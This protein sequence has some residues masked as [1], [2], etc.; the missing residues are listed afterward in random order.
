MFIFNRHVPI[1]PLLFIGVGLVLLIGLGVGVYVVNTQQTD[2]RSKASTAGSATLQNFVSGVGSSITLNTQPFGVSDRNTSNIEATASNCCGGN[3]MEV[4][5]NNASDVENRFEIVFPEKIVEVLGLGT[6]ETAESPNTPYLPNKLADNDFGPGHLQYGMNQDDYN[7]DKGRMKTPVVVFPTKKL[8][9]AYLYNDAMQLRFERDSKTTLV[10]KKKTALKDTANKAKVLVVRGA[11]IEEVYNNYY[12]AL[13]EEGYFFKNPNYA[14]FGPY[15]ETYMDMSCTTNRAGYERLLNSFKSNKIIPSLIVIGSGYWEGA[16]IGCTNKE[17]ARDPIGPLT[18]T[19]GA[20]KTRWN[21]ANGLRQFIDKVHTELKIPILIGMRY[22]VWWA[23]KPAKHREEVEKKILSYSDRYPGV[24]AENIWLNKGQYF[25]GAAP[26]VFGGPFLNLRNDDAIKA[27]HQAVLDSYG[28]V[29]GYKEDNMGVANQSLPHV[30]EYIKGINRDSSYTNLHGKIPE[31]SPRQNLSPDLIPNSY[32]VVNEMTNNKA[33]IIGR[34][35]YLNVGTDAQNT[36]GYFS[37][38]TKWM[39]EYQI[40]YWL[41]MM[42][43]QIASGYPTPVMEYMAYPCVPLEIGDEWTQKDVEESSFTYAESLGGASPEK[44]AFRIHQLQT[45][46]PVA[47][48]SCDYNTRFTKNTQ[49]DG[50]KKVMNFYGAL[51]NRLHDYAY[52]QAQVWYDTGVP[53]LMKP[54]LLDNDYTNLAESKKMLAPCGFFDPEAVNYGTDKATIKDEASAKNC[55]TDG[56][57][58]YQYMFGNALM[59]RPIMSAVDTVAVYLPPGKWRSFIVAN[60]VVD[61]GKTIKYTPKDAGDYPVFLKEGEILLIG[62]VN[63]TKD[64][65]AYAFL[66][67]AG[68][69]E[70]SVYKHVNA[71]TGAKTEL[72]V[73]KQGT[74]LY[75]KDLGSKRQLAMTP[76]VYGKGFYVAKLSALATAPIADTSRVAPTPTPTPRATATPRPTLLPV[77]TTTPRP[78]ARPSTAPTLTPSNDVVALTKQYYLQLNASIPSVNDVKFRTNSALVAQNN[79]TAAIK[80]VTALPT[81]QKRKGPS[82]EKYTDVQYVTMLSRA[83]LSKN[84][85]KVQLKQ[86]T[87]YLKNKKYTRDTIIDFF[88]NSSTAQSVCKAKTLYRNTSF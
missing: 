87:D 34:N 56:V 24:N 58:A 14:V 4:T 73:I 64:L 2:S 52:D 46:L 33:I 57:P 67:T 51:R 32:K 5:Y 68:K 7:G 45:F 53:T 49:N 39:R 77:R 75:L 12:K 78:T 36:G 37:Y 84:P 25:S 8:L 60:P 63:N 71:A 31:V 29:D 16:T 54:L 38:N 41:Q 48:Y 21:G 11:T 44:Q 81:F 88:A 74:T 13:K 9:I 1:K 61:G 69:N 47:M 80:S 66:E 59:V 28:P 43:T 23:S 18:E 26:A 35:D 82:K 22:H 42:I 15:F 86:W 50:Y 65:S 30:L 72:Q 62:D 76:D 20:N 79:C 85:D 70:S 17:T 83:I 6:L 19:F 3:V 55:T 27:W 40:K 10:I